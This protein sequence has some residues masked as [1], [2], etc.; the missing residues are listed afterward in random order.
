MDRYPYLGTLYYLTSVYLR[1]IG[2]HILHITLSAYQVFGAVA[3]EKFS[4]DIDNNALDITLDHFF[5]LIHL[6]IYFY[7][8]HFTSVLVT[9]SLL[10]VCGFRRLICM[11]TEIGSKRTS[12]F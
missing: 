3:G 2:V 8:T 12:S 1:E 9:W 7:F 10:F 5:Y 6:F 4:V 11:H